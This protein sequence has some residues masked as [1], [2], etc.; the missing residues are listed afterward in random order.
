MLTYKEWLSESKYTRRELELLD[1]DELT[2]MAYGVKTGD[3][4]SL[5]PNEIKIKY[6]EDLENPKAIYNC[7]IKKNGLCG[8]DWVKSVSF[9]EPIK[10]SLGIDGKS[11]KE[12]WY[13]ED[14]HHRLFAAKKLKMKSINCE[15]EQVNL[16][17]IEKLLKEQ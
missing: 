1:W 5:N 11:T 13:L 9:E 6:K 16:K 7:E 2:T 10:V 3:I 4:I 12:D 15:V 8:M 14:G 17:A